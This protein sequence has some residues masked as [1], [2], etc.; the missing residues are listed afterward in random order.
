MIQPAH[1][2][3]APMSSLVRGVTLP[4]TTNLADK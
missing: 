2:S 3:A 4:S 1:S